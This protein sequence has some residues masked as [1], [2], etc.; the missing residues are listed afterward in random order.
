[1]LHTTSC[2]VAIKHVGPVVIYKIL[3]PQ[4]LAYD[5]RW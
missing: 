5:P 3:D 2:K 4:L 1:M